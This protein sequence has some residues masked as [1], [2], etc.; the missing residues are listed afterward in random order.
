MVSL[1]DRV[2]DRFFGWMEAEPFIGLLMV[3]TAIVLF[4]SAIRR[5]PDRSKTLWPWVRRI[6]ESS[7]GA[8][9]FLGLLWAFRTI[10]NDNLATFNS[11]HGSLTDANLASAQSIWGRPHVQRELTLAHYIYVT[12]LEEIPRQNPDDP[13][14]YKEVT[15]RINVPQNSM[16]GFTGS[17]DMQLSER[18]KGYGLYSGFIVDASLTYDIINDSD[19]DTEVDFVF[20]LAPSQML[21]E[22]FTIFFDGED[23]SSALRFGGDLIQ[24]QGNMT[25]HQQSKIEVAYRSR[26][27]SYLYYQ[28]PNQRQIKNFA[29]TVT[30]DKLHVSLLN[31][32]DRVLSPTHIAET[33]GG[34]GSI[35]TWELD[36]AI[37][38]AGMGVALLQPEQPG[39]RVFRVLNISGLALTTLLALVAI[40]LLL[41]D[42][43]IHLVDLGLLGGMYCALFLVMSGISDYSFGFWGSLI[44]GGA[45]TLIL[46]GLILR[47]QPPVTRWLVLGLVAFFTV[48]YP[49]YGQ[50]SEATDANAFDTLVRV[51]SA[52]Y[53]VV[54]ALFARRRGSPAA[55]TSI[56]DQALS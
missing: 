33:N 6:I 42:Q 35:L 47:R 20:P 8:I 22:N 54:V 2:F 18:E 36:N 32:P 37:T 46:T 39:E 52:V 48:I 45:L 38:T 56:P 13:P 31:Y 51:G 43:S 17:F 50:I 15:R 21:F 19:K 11:T 55:E 41:L 34:K 1:L 14:Q 9:L 5:D 10:L 7:A 53:I 40:T 26:G 29:L 27:M 4:A 28:I 16:L 24:W 12:E 44:V 49:L 23:I 3:V 30:V 25:A